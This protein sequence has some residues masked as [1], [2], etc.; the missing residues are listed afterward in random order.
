MER[1]AGKRILLITPNL[2]LHP[3]RGNTAR[4]AAVMDHLRTRG[5]SLHVVLTANRCPSYRERSGLLSSVESYKFIS[6]AG[7]ALPPSVALPLKQATRA[8]KSTWRRLTGW[9]QRLCGNSGDVYDQLARLVARYSP[10]ILWLNY[11]Y[12][13]PLLTKVPRQAGCLWVVDTH[14]CMHTR[15]ASLI[16]AGLP[17]HYGVSRQDEAALLEL[18]DLILAIQDNEAEQLRQLVPH[19]QIITV[20]HCVTA[21]PAKATEPV[22]CFVAGKGSSN[23]QGICTFL[24]G[25]W[26]KIEH[27][28]PEARLH[29]VGRICSEEPLRQLAGRF[30]SV[31][32]R[33]HVSD[34]SAVYQGPAV[35]I[36]PLWAGSGLKIKM[37]EALAHGK[38]VVT[39]PIGAQGMEDGL[40]QA[41]IAVEK[42]EDFAEPIVSLLRDRAR[43]Q[44]L[45]NAAYQYGRKKFGPEEVYQELDHILDGGLGVPRKLSA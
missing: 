3:Y 39:T 26:G 17:P 10:D 7:C 5:H 8:G 33:G 38:A 40:G 4:L 9:W 45:E 13:A 43:R 18:F 37:V 24:E 42:A 30:P 36:C 44:S 15:D 12:L 35:M 19:R 1:T 2:P 25:A 11:A 29:I 27:A 28:C 16:Q 31:V 32:L 14:D 22:V 20:G 23:L 6:L 41:F 21:L 34:L